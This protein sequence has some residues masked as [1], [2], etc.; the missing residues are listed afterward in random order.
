MRV[1]EKPSEYGFRDK[2]SYEESAYYND[3]SVDK[4][5]DGVSRSD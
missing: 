5:M 3:D 2:K 1:S 4:A